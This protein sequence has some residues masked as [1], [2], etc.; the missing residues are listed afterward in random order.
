MPSR[1]GRY[2][3][4]AR[5]T[6]TM[7]GIK[8]RYKRKPMTSGR[9]KRIIGAEL[10][11]KT[12][13]L[14]GAVF[15]TAN[16]RMIKLTDISQGNGAN[17]REGN[18]IT[19][20]NCHGNLTC[21]ADPAGATDTINVRVC[22]LRWNE[23]ASLGDPTEAI[24]MNNI[25]QLGG[26]FNIGNKGMF[27]ILWSR[28]FVLVNDKQNPSFKKTFRYYIRT[29]APKILYDGAATAKKYQIYLAAFAETADSPQI[30][31]DNTFRFTDS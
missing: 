2:K 17:E 3:K 24:L 13:S 28:Y 18:R 14:G 27:K 8:R 31:F 4:R 16:P 22:I 1:Y 6:R 10:K 11:F 20:V 9:V 25:T 26:A 21:V 23:D 12:V 7:G 5:K 19:P 15:N 29:S 30:T